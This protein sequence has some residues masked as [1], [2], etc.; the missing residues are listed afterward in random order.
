MD[1][2]GRFLERGMDN[3]QPRIEEVIGDR[4]TSMGFST[5]DVDK[6]WNT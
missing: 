5:R 1:I 2:I 4:A 6:A 3:R